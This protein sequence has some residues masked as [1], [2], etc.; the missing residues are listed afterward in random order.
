MNDARS[1]GEADEARQGVDETAGLST[2]FPLF[3]LWLVHTAP[4]L[5][6][7]LSLFFLSLLSVA[8]GTVAVKLDGQDGSKLKVRLHIPSCFDNLSEEDTADSFDDLV[9]S[10]GEDDSEPYSPSLAPA[11]ERQRDRALG[12]WRHAKF[13]E[14]DATAFRICKT[15]LKFYFASSKQERLTLGPE[16]Y[17]MA[18][19]AKSARSLNA[20]WKSLFAAAD[21]EVLAPLRR[22]RDDDRRILK[23]PK[24]Y[25]GSADTGPVTKINHWIYYEG[26]REMGLA[27]VPEYTTVEMTTRDI[28]VI[29]KT[30]WA[31]A[32]SMTAFQRII[33]YA[34]VIIFSL[35]FR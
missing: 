24:N 35:G 2:P 3:A 17:V 16:E 25:P 34:L 1:R 28:A 9:D 27:T 30:L 14:N 15:F 20:F 22:S 5:L 10:D 13:W 21:A 11:T 18:K 26:A 8:A 32:D 19:T 31:S 6:F 12:S 4:T 7:L 23:G 33:F 29:L